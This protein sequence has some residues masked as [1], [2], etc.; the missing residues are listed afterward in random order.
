MAGAQRTAQGGSSTALPDGARAMG[1]LERPVDRELPLGS[2]LHRH[3]H[4][5]GAMER[6][7]R[8]LLPRCC[9]AASKP[10]RHY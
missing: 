5:M 9:D 6:T 3:A 4:L 1:R 7:K 8:T 2:R 10:T